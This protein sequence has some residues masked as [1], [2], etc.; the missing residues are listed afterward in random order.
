MEIETLNLDQWEAL[1]DSSEQGTIFHRGLYLES[2]GL[3]CDF[4]AFQKKGNILG[5]MALPRG[6][7]LQVLPYQAYNGFIFHPDVEA[8]KQVSKLELKF[9]MTEFI[10]TDLLERYD[11]ITFNAI[12]YHEACDLRPFHWKNYNEMELPTYTSNVVYT[13]ILNTSYPLDQSMLRKGRKSA[14]HKGRKFGLKTE[15]SENLRDMEKIYME[16]FVR[17]EID[18]PEETLKLSRKLFKNLI[19]SKKAFLSATYC[20]NELASISLFARDNKRAYY[21]FGA[22][23]TEFRAKETGTENLAWSIE[24]IKNELKINFLDMVGVNSPQ[25][26]SFKLSFGGQLVPYYQL[27]K[28]NER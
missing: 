22:N 27:T 12:D 16:T 4:L 11:E 23:K 25:R 1:V 3:D 6:K 18:L 24:Y 19:E 5:A 17:Q 8:K 13:S 2:L 20:E 21:L 10:A 26:G 9:Q 14:L 15:L 7:K 28:T